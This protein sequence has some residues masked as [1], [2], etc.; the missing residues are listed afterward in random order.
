MEI[1]IIAIRF[2]YRLNFSGSDSASFPINAF[3]QTFINIKHIYTVSNGKM[4]CC[5]FPQTDISRIKST[6]IFTA[7][8]T[9]LTIV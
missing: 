5:L 2:V 1:I 8:T 6:N 9:G 7:K 4:F 3:S